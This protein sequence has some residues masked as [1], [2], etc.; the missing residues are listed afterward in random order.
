M[1]PRYYRMPVIS[2]AGSNLPQH[3]DVVLLG[4]KKVWMFRTI[5][6]LSRLR[7]EP[8]E[9]HCNE[10][11]LRHNRSTVRTDYL[12]YCTTRLHNEN[13]MKKPQL[14]RYLIIIYV[15]YFCTAQN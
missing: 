3:T 12:I 10:L 2:S 4:Q 8:D 9:N 5:M 11:H 14:E 13:K 15:F 7:I 1:F 6:I